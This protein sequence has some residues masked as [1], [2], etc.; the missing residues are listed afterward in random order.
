LRRAAPTTNGCPTHNFEIDTALQGRTVRPPHGTVLW[1]SAPQ[2]RVSPCHSGGKGSKERASRHYRSCGFEKPEGITR[3][4]REQHNPFNI[5]SEASWV[6]SL[7]QI[8]ISWSHWTCGS[9]TSNPNIG[10]ALCA[11]SRGLTVIAT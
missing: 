1:R 6:V 7:T 4:E 5:R 8:A 10:R 9:G 2:T 11:L 3:Q